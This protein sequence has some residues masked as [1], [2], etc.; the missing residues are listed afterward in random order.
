MKKLALSAIA[1]GILLFAWSAV[2]WMVLPWHNATLKAF[3]GE[4]FVIAT[5]VAG[6]ND[7]GVYV[8]PYMQHGDKDA[9]KRNAGKPFAFVVYNQKGWGNSGVH[10]GLALL[11]DILSAF[12]AALLLFK[13]KIKDFGQKVLFVTALGLFAGM[14][15]DISNMV[16]WGYSLSFTALALA[17]LLISWCLAGAVIAKILD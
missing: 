10:M 11:W 13:T 16:W 14:A 15:V 3:K 7:S 6:K 12:L 9:A 2:S 17:D 1:G 5:M 4:P 8:M